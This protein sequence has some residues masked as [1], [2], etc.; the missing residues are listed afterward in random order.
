MG[1]YKIRKVKTDGTVSFQVGRYEMRGVP[2]YRRS[3]FKVEVH[4]GE[5][6][7]VE[8]A[9]SEWPREIARLREIGRERKVETLQGK[10]D[11]LKELTA[12]ED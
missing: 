1:E 6:A 3:A 2:G 11:R 10:L 8:A 4:L 9:L 12:K 5:Y 7:S